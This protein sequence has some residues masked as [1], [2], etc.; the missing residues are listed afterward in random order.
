MFG[1][2]ILLLVGS[3]RAQETPDLVPAPKVITSMAE[4]WGLTDAE[5]A[6]THRYR[7]ECDVIYYD[8]VWKNL[9]IQDAT[10]GGYVSVGNRKLPIKSGEHIIVTGTFEP[11][12]R[13]LSFEHGTVIASS[14]ANIPVLDAGGQLRRSDVLGNRLVSLEAF[15]VRQYRIDPDHLQMTLSAEGETITAYVSLDGAQAVPDFS[16]STIRIRGVYL[17]KG[18]DGVR[19]LI[20][21]RVSGVEDVAVINW[22]GTDPRFKLPITP[23]ESL[24]SRQRQTLVRVAGRVKGQESGRYLTI[25][26]A[27]GQVDLMTMQDR[28]FAIDEEVEAIG[29]PSIEGTAWKLESA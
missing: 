27:T 14:P 18:S 24:A 28:V 2:A 22:L 3:G 23:I 7:I 20:E 9:W 19:L 4:F 8:A 11:P 17:T 6:Q 16:E 25:R 21:L 5:R 26:D 29:Y 10:Q 12:N 1:A 13:D 15:V